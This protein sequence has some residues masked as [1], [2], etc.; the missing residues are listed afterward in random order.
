MI[1]FWYISNA[2]IIV[3]SQENINNSLIDLQKNQDFYFSKEQIE[4][5]LKKKS[6]E[7]NEENPKF[8]YKK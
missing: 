7:K 4:Y 6:M 2:N 3:K 8:N 1:L 5:Y